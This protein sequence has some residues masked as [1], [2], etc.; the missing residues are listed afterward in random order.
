MNMF[1]PGQQKNHQAILRI[2]TQFARSFATY[3]LTR[4]IIRKPDSNLALKP[5][6]SFYAR[7]FYLVCKRIGISTAYIQTYEI[8]YTELEYL[9]V[10]GVFGLPR[11]VIESEEAIDFYGEK[12]FTYDDYLFKDSH[13]SYL[14]GF[15]FDPSEIKKNFDL[16]HYFKQRPASHHAKVIQNINFIAQALA[17]DEERNCIGIDLDTTGTDSWL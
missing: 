5:L 11:D 16:S 13:Y 14:R 9:V 6:Y 1:Q 10:K 8:F 15:Y 17:D 7:D 4:S 2:R 3:W 12:S